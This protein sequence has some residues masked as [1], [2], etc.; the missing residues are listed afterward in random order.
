MLKEESCRLDILKLWLSVMVV[1]IHSA[2]KAVDFHG[3]SIVFDVPVWLA[4]IRYIIS[5]AIARCAVPGFFFMAAMFLYSKKFSW[6]ANVRKKVKTLV[7]PFL[8][9]NTFWLAFDYFTQEVLALSP[10]FSKPENIV[11]NWDLTRYFE[12]YLTNGNLALST[13]WFIRDLFVLN[14][15]APVIVKILDPFPKISFV[16]LLVMWLFVPNEL[17]RSSHL[18]LQAICFFGFGCL[19]VRHGPRL[20]AL[21][22]IPA[23]VHWSVYIALITAGVFLRNALISRICVLYGIVFWYSCM[24]N[25]KAVGLKNFLLKFSAFNFCIYIFHERI[26]SLTRN[27]LTRFF[28]HTPAFQFCLYIFQPVLIIIYCVILSMLLKKYFPRLFG[29]VTGDRI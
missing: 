6:I 2:E 29:L 9:L 15:F 13:T 12:A 24:T 7:I 17:F 25:F 8:M 18:E 27:Y 28:E 22:K 14:L 5:S 3:E 1:Y 10:F 19:F 16:V 23:F 11:A 4:T 21:D 20:E 26:L